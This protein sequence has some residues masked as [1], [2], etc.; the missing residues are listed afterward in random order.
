MQQNWYHY[1]FGKTI[2]PF[3]FSQI[4][5]QI[6]TNQISKDD[7]VYKD[8]SNRWIKVGEIEEFLDVTCKTDPSSFEVIKDF[9]ILKADKNRQLGPYSMDMVL[10]KIHSGE[11]EFQ[12]YIWQKGMVSFKPVHEIIDP[13]NKTKLCVKIQDD[14]DIGDVSNEELLDSV[15]YHDDLQDIPKEAG[16]VDLCEQ[17]CNFVGN[18]QS[19]NKPLTDK[20]NE[21]QSKT[22]KN[23]KTQVINKCLVV[24]LLMIAQPIS[25]QTKLNNVI[26]H[27]A[28]E[29]NQLDI[30]VPN[31]EN[32][33]IKLILS[34]KKNQILSKNIFYHEFDLNLD[35]DATAMLRLDQWNLSTGYYKLQIDVKGAI[36]DGEFFFGEDVTKFKTQLIAF[37]QN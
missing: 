15:L 5:F 18:T 16:T 24:L 33:K 31:A 17:F 12:D 28:Q 22:M 27:T 30:L 7:L 29:G 37:N 21:S 6:Q 4:K 26:Y 11:I 1:K 36:F 25:S 35:D 20:N 2:G 3:S 10:E 34:S 23:S 19:F 14:D 8:G 32:Q 9:V 13:D